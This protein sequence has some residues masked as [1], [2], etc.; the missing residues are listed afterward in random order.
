MV[1]AEADD[2]VGQA[3]DILSA[4]VGD[5]GEA[6]AVDQDL[7]GGR[8]AVFAGEGA[9]VE[10][11][12]VG[13]AAGAGELFAAAALDFFSRGAAQ[14]NDEPD[15]AGECDDAGCDAADEPGI[16]MVQQPSEVLE[17]GIQGS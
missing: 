16:A 10:D 5:A 14:V 1:D 13:D 3:G 6:V 11:D 15:E 8:D 2:L 17:G 9:G 12:A 4:V 7:G